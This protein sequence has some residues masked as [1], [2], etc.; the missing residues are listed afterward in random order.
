M[1]TA[2]LRS[3]ASILLACLLSPPMTLFAV[4]REPSAQKVTGQESALEVR[5]FTIVPAASNEAGRKQVRDVTEFVYE[6]LQYMLYGADGREAALKQGRR[7]EYH[8]RDPST[9]MIT[10]VDT[11]PNL[12][13]AEEYIATVVVADPRQCTYN[14]RYGDVWKVTEDVVRELSRKCPERTLS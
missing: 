8:Q 14:V 1:Q 11:E 4:A 5:T 10:I 6:I 12:K 13:R 9:G 2:C 3:I 7:M